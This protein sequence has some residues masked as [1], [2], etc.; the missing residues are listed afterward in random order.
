MGTQPRRVGRPRKRTQRVELRLNAD[1]PMYAALVDEATR[2]HVTLQQ[3][4]TDI[5][6][7]RYLSERAFEIAAPPPAT[8][9]AGALVDEWM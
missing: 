8:D 2:R 6:V 9:N 7:A 3:H 5:L 4:I 1:D